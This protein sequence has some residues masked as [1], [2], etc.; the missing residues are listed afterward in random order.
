MPTSATPC[1]T[2]LRLNDFFCI[3]RFKKTV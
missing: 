1:S 3:E 2:L